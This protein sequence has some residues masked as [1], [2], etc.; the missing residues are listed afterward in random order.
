LQGK[1]HVHSVGHE[2]EVL[3]YFVVCGMRA[4]IVPRE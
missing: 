1:A 4:M 2:I 3:T